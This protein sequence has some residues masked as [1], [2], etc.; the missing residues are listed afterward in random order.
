MLFKARELGFE[1]IAT[2]HYAQV[3]HGSLSASKLSGTASRPGRLAAATRAADVPENSEPD[4]SLLAAKDTNKDQTYF[5]YRISEDAL[6]RTLFP[7]GNLTKP[8]VRAEAKKRGLATAKR[9]ESMGICFVGNVGIKE[10]LSQYVKTKPGDIIEKET[11]EKIGRHDGAIYYTFGQRH[12]L[13]VGGGM[14]Y[15]VVGKD[16]AKNE[17]YVSTNLNDESFWR[18]ELDLTKIHWI[19]QR[20]ETEKLYK[21]RLRHRG[22]LLPCKIDGDKVILEQP[23]R[24]IAPGQSAVIYDCD[25]CLG[26]GVVV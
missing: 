19:R 2:G 15:Y 14:P 17:V 8:Q 7:I 18:T 5:L 20:P 23:E 11:G 13:G 24:A 12:N 4:A 16:M 26:G 3:G 25:V 22:K 6:K 10:F 21:V 1:N 9:R